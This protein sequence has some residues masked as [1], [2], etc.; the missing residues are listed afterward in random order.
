MKKVLLPIITIIL[1]ILVFFIIHNRPHNNPHIIRVS[2]NI[3]VDDIELSFKISGRVEKRFVSEG[4]TVKKNQTIATL[5]K[6]ELINEV[7]VRKAE[8]QSAEASLAELEAGSRPEEIAQAEA[9]VK[10]AQAKLNELIAGSRPQEISSAQAAVERAKAEMER[11]KSEY[12]RNQKLFD[13]KI[14]S[15]QEF[16]IAKTAYKS[17]NTVLKEAEEHLKLVKE[18]PRQE[19]IDQARAAL[20]E[21]KEQ[22]ALIKKGPRKE[23]IDQAQARLQ[24]AKETLALAETRLGYAILISPISGIVLSKNIEPGEYV[25]PGTPV[26]TVGNLEQVWLRAYINET[27]LGRIKIGQKVHII[28]DTYPEK[29]YEGE[30]SFISSETEFTPK[31]VQTEKERVKLVYLIKIT[32]QNPNMELK[33]GMPADAEI[34]LSKD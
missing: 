33:S 3:E 10:K 22:Y 23:T 6:S 8:V 26:V 24:Q 30:I 13:E 27:D 32:I 19:E 34:L 5:E 29:L 14:I 2:G 18:G 15:A 31:T 16:D 9:S 1:V 17:A 28:S 21:T 12:E 25:S 11:L 4:D 7:N 20:K